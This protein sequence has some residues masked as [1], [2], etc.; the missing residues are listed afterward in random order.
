MSDFNY[1]DLSST[2]AGMYYQP[3]YA[4]S[5]DATDIIINSYNPNATKVWSTYFG[6][7]GNRFVYPLGYDFPSALAAFDNIALYG[8]GYSGRNIPLQDYNAVS[9]LDYYQENA[10]ANSSY[11]T[12]DGFISRFN[13]EMLGVGVKESIVE[14]DGLILYPNP[15]NT[16]IN[17]ADTKLLGLD[18][19]VKVFDITGRLIFNN[20]FKNSPSM[21][22]L[23]V[24]HLA[25]GAYVV[26]IV[27]DTYAKTSRFVKE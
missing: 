16:L 9:T 26:Q 14:K 25:S 22:T 18:V 19:Q 12:N 6:E 1:D 10:S 3:S 4:G 24:S 8:V 7:D 21:L 27:S 11:V 23:D 20:N 13:L 17:L 5:A 15:S 2:P